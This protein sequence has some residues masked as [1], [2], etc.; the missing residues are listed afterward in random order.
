MN[1]METIAAR[2][3][4][5]QYEERPVEREKIQEVLEAMR[6]APSACNGQKWKFFAV[7]DPALRE[8][9]ASICLGGP[10][11]IRHAPVI[12]IA[13]GYGPGIMTCGH[14]AS[15]V[16]LTIPMSYATLEAVELGLGTC[17][18]ASFRQEDVCEIL[19]LDD[20]WRIPL[21]ATLGYAA[22]A[23][24]ARPRKAADEVTAILSG[25]EK[26]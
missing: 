14:D 26:T 4:I 22:E 19:G 17:L 23:P 8:K 3:S 12:L 13:A 10:E 15:S 7:A 25:L 6:L 9:I 16:D 1:V 24:G 5:R 20:T 2:R 11:W 18:I 21:I